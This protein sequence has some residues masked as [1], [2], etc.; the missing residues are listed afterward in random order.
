MENRQTTY[1]QKNKALLMGTIIYAIGNLGTRFLSFL[2]V[3]LYTHFIAPAE[4]G[5]YDLMTTTIN[6]IAPFISFQITDA[7][8]RWMVSDDSY[9]KPCISQIYRVLIVNSILAAFIVLLINCF[10]P[11]YYCPYFIA[12]L[13][14]GRWQE[15]L[16]KIL[17]GLKQQKLYA[18]SGII[19]TALFVFLNL[20]K[21][22]IQHKGV[23][24]LLESSVIAPSLTI[25]FMLIVE[26]RLRKF[27]IFDKNIK[28][29]K[30]MIKY[31][32][33]LIPTTLN[34]WVM[35]AS[36]RYIIKLFLGSTA[37]GI[38]AVANK[39][40]T[41]LSTIFTMFITSWT[42][43]VL[44]EDSHDEKIAEYYSGIFRKF[45]KL[46]FGL[47]IFLVPATKIAC[48][49]ILDESYLSAMNY[50]PFLYLGSVFQA[51]SSF[52]SIGY[53]RDKST[54]GAATTSVCGAIVNFCVNILLVRFIGLH[55]ASF[56]TF[57]GFL[58]M[59]IIRMLQTKYTLPI[60]ISRIGFL[61]RLLLTLG[62]CVITILSPLNIS[63]ILCFI[64]LLYFG[65]DNWNELK[66]LI[67]FLLK[68][69]NVKH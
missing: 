45:Y 5:D 65:T 30:Q 16:Q 31:S 64:A 19:Y 48:Y 4:L 20:Y 27:N 12:I 18:V 28:L 6:L 43:L 35:S 53:L 67:V 26:K 7:A 33:P 66:I 60:S 50:I 54:G 61:V 11:V 57:V 25:L 42:D 47:T 29:L 34:W 13:I 55:A 10:T 41:I 44:S 22:T 15:S 32:I 3:P 56:S 59:W 62:I 51:F 69:M 39:F 14:L 58:I 23:V 21:I 9:I 46:A 52:Y 38:Y 8:Y 17:R 1:N 40:P 2:I 37:N 36:D 24:A 68:K 49:L 63:I